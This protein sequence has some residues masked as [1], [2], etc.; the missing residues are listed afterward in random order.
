[1]TTIAYDGRYVAVDSQVTIGDLKVTQDKS[2]TV[3]TAS[4]KSLVVFGAGS[5]ADIQ[6]AVDLLADDKERLP[7]GDY[8]LVVCGLREHPVVYESDGNPIDTLGRPY[9]AGSGQQAALAALILGVN[10]KRAVEVACEVDLHSGPPVRV[11]DTKTGKFKAAPRRKTTP[12][13]G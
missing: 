8:S 9:V 12:K 4:G 5:V 6:A 7:E 1:M 2:Y 3:E 11:F 13:G 10:A